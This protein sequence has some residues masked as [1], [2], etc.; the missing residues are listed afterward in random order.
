MQDLLSE[1]FMVRIVSLAAQRT[2]IRS[3]V[4]PRLA[5]MTQKPRSAI[6]INHSRWRFL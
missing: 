5:V 4:T 1:P 6:S 2:A 3:L